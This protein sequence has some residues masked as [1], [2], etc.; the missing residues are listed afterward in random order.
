MRRSNKE[1][2][3][4]EFAF[5]FIMATVMLLGISQVITSQSFLYK[6]HSKIK[7]RLDIEARLS[8]VILRLKDAY[9]QAAVKPLCGTDLISRSFQG[10]SF[11]LPPGDDLCVKLTE[12]I[13]GN[14]REVEIC[15]SIKDADLNWK[16]P[17]AG[18]FFREDEKP[19]IHRPGDGVRSIE[20]PVETDFLWKQCD[21]PNVCIRVLLCLDGTSGCS[22]DD[23]EA[24]QVVK[25]GD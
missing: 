3:T 2:G 17:N 9:N 24:Y 23:A 7:T 13:A 6:S 11:C 10:G 19:I 15:T 1:S 16:N 5:V 4:I 22:F 8:A 20:I 25:M 21:T 12:V 18:S 14:E